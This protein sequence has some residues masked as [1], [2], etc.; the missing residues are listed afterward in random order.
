MKKQLTFKKLSLFVLTALLFALLSL[1]F[2]FTGTARA[3]ADEESQPCPDGEHSLGEVYPVLEP[4][5]VYPGIG[6]RYCDKCGLSFTVIIPADGVS[7]SV[8]VTG[9]CTY[10][11]AEDVDYVITETYDNYVEVGQVENSELKEIVIPA[12]VMTK[13]GEKDVHVAEN[14]F[15]DNTTITS[16]TIGGAA[17][18]G[19]S[20]F[21]GCTSLTSVT[22]QHSGD[23][24]T[25]S[26]GADAFKGCT[27]LTEI[28]LADGLTSIGKGAFENTAYY[29]NTEQ[30]SKAE[31]GSLE[32]LSIGSYLIK[33]KA[34]ETQPAAP[35][36]LLADAEGEL[37]FTVPQ[38]TAVIADG[39]FDGLA[40]TE[41]TL[42]AE[43]TAL[44]KDFKDMTGLERIYIEALDGK[45]FGVTP[46][47]FPAGVPV[48]YKGGY[49]EQF[50]NLNKI[51]SI[52]YYSMTEPADKSHKYWH[53]G[54]GGGAEVWP[55]ITA[56]TLDTTQ[57]PTTFAKGNE[58]SYEG[59][60]VT[61]VYDDG[62]N[63]SIAAGEGG[64]TVDSAAYQ[65]D[66][67]GTYTI[68]V[69][70]LYA[71]AHYDVTVAESFTVTV[72]YNDGDTTP[73]EEFHVFENG[74]FELPAAPTRTGYKFLGWKVG[75][76][77]TLHDPGDKIPVSAD[78]TVTAQW[79]KLYTVTAAQNDH[80]TVTFDSQKDYYV[81]GDTVTF[82]VE[83]NAGFKL[84]A[85]KNGEEVL[86]AGEDG[87]YTVTVGT[88]DIVIT[89]ETAEVA[90]TASALDGGQPLE[91]NVTQERSPD[92]ASVTFT[93]TAPAKEGQTFSG[94]Q[95]TVDGVQQ[96]GL[97]TEGTY[98]L[99]LGNADVTV[100]FTATWTAAYTVTVNVEG[101]G[102]GH[103][104]YEFEA[105][106]PYTEGTEVKF[107][108]T[109]ENGYYIATVKNGGEDL[110]VGDDGWYTVTVGTENIV[111]TVTTAEV[112]VEAKLKEAEGAVINIAYS[113]DRTQATLKVTT[114][115][116]K[117]GYFFKGWTVTKQ[118]GSGDPVS[119]EFTDSLTIDLEHANVTVIFT[120]TWEINYGTM[121]APLS[122]EEA[123]YLAQ[124][125]EQLGS[126]KWTMSQVY[127]TGKVKE[128]PEDAGGNEIQF[129]L[130]DLTDDSKEITVWKPTGGDI[131]MVAQNDIL[132]IYGW[133]ENYK[134]EKLEVTG[135][136][137][138]EKEF[139]ELKTR[140][141]GQSTITLGEHDGATVTEFGAQTELTAKNDDEFTFT[142]QP[143]EG[144]KVNT[145]MAGDT[146]LTAESGNTYKFT[147]KGNVTI[148]ITTI[149]EG[150]AVSQTAKM[151]YPGG[152]NPEDTKNMS[153]GEGTPKNATLVGLDENIFKV[154]STK[155]LGTVH[156]GLNKDG[157]I[158]LYKNK[159][160]ELGIEVVSGYT[161]ESINV[162]LSSSSLA[163]IA[164]LYVKV[165][166]A[167]VTGNN[168]LYTIND[169]KVTLW[170]TDKDKQI[171]IKTILITYKST[172][173]QP[174]PGED[175]DLK[176]A[177]AALNS[178]TI[179]DNV[180]E[181][182][183]IALPADNDAGVTYQW[184]LTDGAN[185]ATLEGN[186]LTITR[187][188]TAA[189]VKLSATATYNG[190]ITEPKEFTITV[191]AE[192]AG[193]EGGGET[194]VSGSFTITVTNAT[195]K[196][197]SQ[198]KG[199]WT[200]D[201]DPAGDTLSGSLFA[202]AQGSILQFKGDPSYV[203]NNVA[204]PAPLSKIEITCKTGSNIKK[205]FWNLLTSTSVCQLSEGDKNPS[206]SETAY[207]QQQ[208]QYSQ[209]DVGTTLTWDI[210]NGDTFFVLYLTGDAA[211][212]VY[213]I[214][215]TYGEAAAEAAM[216]A[217]A[218]TAFTSNA[219]GGSAA[220]NGLWLC[221]AVGGTV[222][223]VLVTVTAVFV[224]RK[225]D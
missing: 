44:G 134:G 177:Q 30:W 138:D 216:E 85:V 98:T 25:T 2:A 173:A 136:A 159:S 116:T 161:I 19:A 51:P 32:S 9:K 146:V 69:S 5:C 151:E 212:T 33:V 221:V 68:T 22:I 210:T 14:A 143:E 167:Q 137:S 38:N 171:Y 20:A 13:D 61:A 165:G 131:N 130:V 55:E 113:E 187:I 27:S 67:P 132:L 47:Q 163:K 92:G 52:H 99:E 56:L 152:P 75:E 95:V 108:L 87:K 176:T 160:V 91:D 200:A 186:T 201:S 214:K 122:V 193:P 184:T 102:S 64:Y 191:S 145:V 129:V 169:T 124:D 202:V 194:K 31:V 62:T 156:V 150:E 42:N 54:E 198:V 43:L 192:S 93:L 204:T 103:A 224:F 57:C 223:A 115:P 195:L 135:Y 197:A 89:V 213:S 110:T 76:E 189:T 183:T 34:T 60:T 48:F 7:H 166:T 72:D 18:I 71:S 190:K 225:K 82:T 105:E 164:Q 80:A 58:F 83:V 8:D 41:V 50:T 174:E 59:L 218:M 133:I 86:T 39:A 157:T 208:V 16:V 90:V 217:P 188:A 100:T 88:A 81:E 78:I 23:H 158:R 185:V 96:E 118:V 53:E 37:A 155:N 70:Y 109:V 172:S 49:N 180:T 168:G 205:A 162:T 120:A 40:L 123:L 140:T 111:I 65:K 73:S 182:K 36:A 97:I 21:E 206:P 28:M 26:I 84:T 121:E 46:D 220:N 17:E 181:D 222:L 147:V 6:V 203:M 3:H 215:I 199:T 126:N 10:C 117:K 142:V 127:L 104:T 106:G 139:P 211:A 24:I 94:W 4:T 1:A 179:E 15:K 219:N 79:E 196:G 119:V 74:A 178:L 12:I 107:M 77:E 149:A 153:N 63:K 45:D 114:E 112:T 66:T 148:T 154:T 209:E 11:G 170:N 101:E 128:N 141:P 125:I 144:K 207:T 35:V 29:N 175:A